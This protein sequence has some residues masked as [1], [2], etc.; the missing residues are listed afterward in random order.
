MR[1]VMCVWFPL[2]PVQ[3]LRCAASAKLRK[4]IQREGS[5]QRPVILFAEGRRGFQVVVCCPEVHRWGIRVGMPL[6]E[7]RS[8]LPGSGPPS[9][10]S[11]PQET[12][13]QGTKR[14]R[15][16]ASPLLK[17][18]NPVADRIQLQALAHYCNRY[19][20]LVGLEET[21]APESL[22]LDIS[23][24]EALFGGE[25][26]LAETVRRDMAQQGMQVRVAIAD[27]W[28]AAW[29]V[30]HFGEA[31]IALVPPGQQSEWLAPL[32]VAALRITEPLRQSL[33]TLDI[34]KVAQLWQLPRTSLPSRF[35]KELVQ[36][37]DQARGLIPELLVAERPSEP[38]FTEWLFEEP[39][40]D[41]QTL[42]HVCEVLLERLLARLL[43]RQAGLRE[44]QCHW[45]GTPVEPTVL[46]MLRPV[47]E[48]R[49]LLELLRLQN[50][51]RVFLSKVQ[52]V[53][54]EAVEIGLPPIRQAQLFD[55]DTADKHPQLLAELVDRLSI[56]LGC[57]A[58]LH[59][60]LTPDPQPEFAC[61][62]IPW[63]NA[64][65]A[66]QIRL[67]PSGLRCRPLRL[68][69]SPQPLLVEENSPDGLPSRV[70]RSCVV[71]IAGPERIEAGWWR[72][73][74]AKRDYYRLDLANGARLW[75]FVTRDTG[76]WFLH[77]LFA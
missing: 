62:S 31:D 64:K 72:G 19:S 58:V 21:T 28:G 43:E 8:L 60:R 59:P 11:Q 71:R 22:W 48:K 17:R 70:H 2:W 29:G 5:E 55:D 32:P 23:G 47:N 37:M 61:E 15:S 12:K 41:R 18:A 49:H 53:R 16:A 7:V 26:G 14:T 39:I 27:S 35:G 9:W 33:E 75:V 40:D 6:G 4:G 10:S 34:T 76:D 44:L 68:L 66:A 69:Q 54:M 45:L 13:R 38:L 25:Q 46:R 20:P 77:G 36:R 63:L 74:D 42:D 67:S 65:P 50:E 24:S 1:R 57:G 51:R 3:H 56:R 52:G 73:C 30:S